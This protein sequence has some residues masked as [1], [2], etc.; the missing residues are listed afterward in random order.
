VQGVSHATGQWK[1]R[2]RGGFQ[3]K[4]KKELAA[5]DG[6]VNVRLD[7]P[8]VLVTAAMDFLV[9]LGEDILEVVWGEVFWGGLVAVAVAA[10]LER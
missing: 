10:M 7:A 9:S 3:K 4:K 8:S 2:G 1:S 5:Q 6:E